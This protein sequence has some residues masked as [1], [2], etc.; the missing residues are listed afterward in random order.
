MK[1]ADEVAREIAVRLSLGHITVA[2]TQARREGAEDMRER[3]ALIG[4]RHDTALRFI[5]LTGPQ[6]RALPLPGDE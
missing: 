2:I 3:A 6:I 5:G 1:T 4:D